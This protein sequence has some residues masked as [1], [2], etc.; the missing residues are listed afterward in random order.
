MIIQP[1]VNI[2]EICSQKG[3]RYAVISP[4]SRSAHVTIS[5]ARHPEIQKVVIPDERSAAYIALGLAQRSNA[6]VAL[7]CT[8]G[9]ATINFYPAIAEAYYQNVPLLVLTADR[10]AEWIDKNDGQTIRQTNLYQNHIKKSFTFPESF[11][12]EDAIKSAALIVHEAILL[13]KKSPEGPVHINVPIKE[14]FYPLND[15]EMEFGKGLPEIADEPD[16]TGEVSG[17]EGSV[18]DSLK[19]KKIVIVAGQRHA[20]RDTI[21]LLSKIAK[22]KQIPVFSDVI[23]NAFSS[24]GVLRYHDTFIHSGLTKPDILITFGRSIISKKLKLFLRKHS[25]LVHW[26]ISE[27]DYPADTFLSLAKVLEG[28]V[29][30]FLQMLFSASWK[31]NRDFFEE[32]VK[33]D[34]AAEKVLSNFLDN[35]EF[36]EFKAVNEILRRIPGESILHLANSMP[37][38]YANIINTRKNIEVFANRGTSGIDGCISTAVGHSLITGKLNIVLTGDMAFFYDRNAL[39][40]NFPLPNL[41]I[42]I[43]NNHGGG[44]FRLIDGP[45]QQPELEEYFETRQKL[46]AKNT[47]SDFGM[48]YYLCTSE[49]ELDEVLKN[50]F[51]PTGNGKIL[52]IETNKIVNQKVFTHYKSLT[53]HGT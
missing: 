47:A 37:V 4:G 34:G 28:P 12:S 2:P 17:S 9:T 5:F 39:W 30:R 38:R 35:M 8:S 48:D 46:N 24:P 19:D 16:A 15:E 23:S 7:I 45:S 31:G 27:N 21:S 14:P 1:I 18:F 3:I 51:H 29:N 10:P 20:D 41:R 6:P 44:I 36:G 33:S 43:L 25:N 13:A 42:I 22:E 53:E 52:E 26:H 32:Y 49:M 11:G 50:F 40:H